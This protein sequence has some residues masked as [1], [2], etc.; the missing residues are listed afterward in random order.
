[1]AGEAPFYYARDLIG[2]T[3][4]DRVVRLA[5]IATGGGMRIIF[6]GGYQKIPSA[7]GRKLFIHAKRFG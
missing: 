2:D 1:M 4:R 3:V 6:L 5:R 7:Y